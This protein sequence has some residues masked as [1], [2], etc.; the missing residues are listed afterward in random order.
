[1][2]AVYAIDM[3][4]NADGELSDE[5]YSFTRKATVNGLTGETS[6]ERIYEAINAT[7]MPLLYDAHPVAALAHC[8]V[9][10]LRAVAVGPNWVEVEVTYAQKW[11]ATQREPGVAAQI[12]MEASLLQV[13]TSKDKDGVTLAPLE[14]TYKEGVPKPWNEE[15]TLDADVSPQGEIPIVPTYVPT[16]VYTVT[17]TVVWTVAT[18]E[19][20]NNTYQGRVNSIAWRTY[21]PRTWLC[22][23]INWHS[24]DDGYSFSVT[25]RFQYKYDTYD[26]ELVFRCPYRGK[27]PD[28]VFDSD[29]PDASRTER[30]I[31]E[32]DFNIIDLS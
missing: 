2:P 22:L 20:L 30:I 16:R 13:E 4:D 21:S 18:L 8:L 9:R 32:A 1:M 27:I 10:R 7:G 26:T 29:Q 6:S 17:K 28:D 14:Y 5:G 12:A 31:P 3:I 25:F 15:E 23:G 11:D 19:A 24:N